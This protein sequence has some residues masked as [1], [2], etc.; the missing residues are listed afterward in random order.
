MR[1]SS[2]TGNERVVLGVV[3]DDPAAER[4][5]LRRREKVLEVALSEPRP[6]PPATRIV[7]R[8]SGTPQRSSSAMVTAIAD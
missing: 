1:T 3:D 4:S 7:W 8:S 5:G 6:S 2:P